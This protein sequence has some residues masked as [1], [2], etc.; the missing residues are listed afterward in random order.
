LRL[1]LQLI[2]I[3]GGPGV[4]PI[5]TCMS[6]WCLWEEHQ[7]GFMQSVP[8]VCLSVCEQDN[9]QMHLCM[10]TKHGGHGQGVTL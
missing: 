10:S 8:F 7:G 1:T 3:L 4:I 9:S 2:A 6:H 5:M